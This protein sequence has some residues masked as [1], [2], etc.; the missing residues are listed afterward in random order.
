MTT[1]LLSGC[2][3][4]A[5]NLPVATSPVSRTNA[6]KDVSPIAPAGMKVAISIIAPGKPAITS[7]NDRVM[8]ALELS[9]N[10]EITL[11]SVEAAIYE[12]HLRL[13]ASSRELPDIVS[14]VT[15]ESWT[16]LNNWIGKGI[17]LPFDAAMLAAA[18]EIATQYSGGSESGYDALKVD[19]QIYFQPVW[20]D[21]KPNPNMG[22]FHV[23]KDYLDALGLSPP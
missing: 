1:L 10:T 17:I 2:S 12:D 4:P 15:L 3:Q 9:T 5:Q 8:A 20:W 18:P 16:M 11:L 6:N 22:L 21:H 19:K 14:C 13:L 23:R 7:E